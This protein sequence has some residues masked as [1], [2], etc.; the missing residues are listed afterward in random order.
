MTNVELELEAHGFHAAE[1]IRERLLRLGAEALGHD[2]PALVVTEVARTKTRDAGEDLDY[3]STMDSGAAADGGGS[4]K[5]YQGRVA[6]LVKRPGNPFPQMVSL[7]RARNSDVVLAL[8]T[9]SKVQCY[10]MRDAEQWVIVDQRSRNGTHHNGRALVPGAKTPL[11][12][13]DQIRFGDEVTVRF[14]SPQSL[15]AQLSS[16]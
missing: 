7:G 4:P 8:G 2:A 9:V 3:R 1:S 12:D 16:A 13:G 14:T 15:L 10:F 11:A 6:F 5:L